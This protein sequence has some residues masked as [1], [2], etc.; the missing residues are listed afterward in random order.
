MHG[1]VSD[2]PA[3]CAL[4]PRCRKRRFDNRYAV[5]E[6]NERF[7]RAFESGSLKA[8]TAVW[9]TGDHV[10][11][12]HPLAGCIAG[13]QAVSGRVAGRAWHEAGAV[14]H[15]KARFGGLRL[16]DALRWGLCYWGLRDGEYTGQCSPY[17]A[18]QLAYLAP[19]LPQLSWPIWLMLS[20]NAASK[21]ARLDR[22]A[23]RPRPSPP[24]VMD[25]WKAILGT[26]RMRI[27]IEDV[28]TYAT[29]R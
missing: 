16:Q 27:R 1:P 6:A 18:H 23:G 15:F 29:D 13:R 20:I 22:C 26:G 11:C 3:C 8:M 7:Y 17:M 2:R 12:I 9:G 21:L 5:E 24:Q 28:R 4:W 19:S 25:S 14:P 10:Q